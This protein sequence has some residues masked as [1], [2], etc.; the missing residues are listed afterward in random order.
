M[1]GDGADKDHKQKKNAQ[2]SKQTEQK[3]AATHKAILSTSS[4]IKIAHHEEHEK[5]I[6]EAVRD[7]LEAQATISS[8]VDAGYLK[9][10]IDC[11]CIF[12]LFGFKDEKLF[13]TLTPIFLKNRARIGE[14][15]FN[16][17][18]QAYIKF[19]LPFR[20]GAV[21]MRQVAIVAKGDFMRPSDKPRRAKFKYDRPEPLN[22]P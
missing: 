12:A 21:G 2:F 10:L 16:D 22:A 17:V 5:M 7:R 1:L 18:M 4:K 14:K 3:G 15:E 19:N 8:N 6:Y 13:A 11:V 9:I 20:E